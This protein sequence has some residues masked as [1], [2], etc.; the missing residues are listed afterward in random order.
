MQD[1]VSKS[2]QAS[3]INVADLTAR[4]DAAGLARL[5]GHLAVLALTATMIGWSRDSLFVLP[6]MLL[7]GIVQVA[8]FA[9]LHETVHRTAFKSRWLNDLVAAAIGLV[10]MLPAR[11]FRR[12][13]FAHHRHTQDPERDPELSAPKPTTRW[14]YWLYLSGLYYWRDRSRELIRHAIGRE[15]APFVPE[16]E[17]A[18]VVREARWHLAVY[19]GLF[20]LAALTQ[21]PEPLLFWLFPAI[22]GQPFLRAYLLAEHTGCP[23]CPDMFRNTRTTLSNGLV[24][25]LM[26]EMPYH[27]EH[28][29][30]PAV[31]FHRLP[32]LHVRMADRLAV[33]APGYLAFH[34][35]YRQALGSGAGEAFT[36][37]A[38]AP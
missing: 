19:A 3:R 18:V 15:V 32:E 35:D 16:N 4:S 23:E 22:L 12:F 38:I 9:G 27:T 7:H 37:P 31:P 24:R 11:Y 1:F 28:H 30:F 26:W 10:H 14:R 17:R 13:H 6:A 21:R 20:V 5:A 8:L 2:G 34:G 33:L 29:A 36:K 25:F